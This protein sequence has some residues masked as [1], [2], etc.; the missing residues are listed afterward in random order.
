MSV[1][2][3]YR[4]GTVAAYSMRSGVMRRVLAGMLDVVFLL[5]IQL[6]FQLY[7]YIAAW[8]GSNGWGRVSALTCALCSLWLYSLSDV[9]GRTPGKVMCGLM[10]LSAGGDA[11]NTGHLLIRWVCK[12]WW[13]L[14][15]PA[16]LDRY[17]LSGSIFWQFGLNPPSLIEDHAT[18]FGLLMLG[19]VAI[20]GLIFL[21]PSRRY[22]HDLAAETAVY[23]MVP[24][25]RLNGTH[26]NTLI[27]H[28]STSRRPSS[29][30]PNTRRLG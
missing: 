20:D 24:E 17:R 21:F 10:I 30:P 18:A 12:W 26:V 5:L 1:L 29:N 6:P 15:S 23:A 25:G 19:W 9:F 27:R 11:P 7:E 22:L 8:S 14:A 13:V 2:N 28:A 4:R 3:Y 16:L